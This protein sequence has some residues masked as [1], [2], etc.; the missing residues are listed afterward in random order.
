[1]NMSVR[2]GSCFMQYGNGFASEIKHAND[3]GFN[4]LIRRFHTAD[5]DGTNCNEN[6]AADVHVSHWH[7]DLCSIGSHH[8]R[9]SDDRAL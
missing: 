9:P 5:S 3:I 1:M 4:T 8:S 6:T 7:K 2:L